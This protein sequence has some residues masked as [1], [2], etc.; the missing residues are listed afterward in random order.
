MAKA[1]NQ[2]QAD[3]V[4]IIRATTLVFSAAL[5]LVACSEPPAAVPA[6]PDQIAKIERVLER[7][8]E[9]MEIYEKAK[10]DD[11]VTEQEIIEILQQA[12]S[13]KDMREVKGDS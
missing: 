11:V 8:P 7:F 10:S 3:M 9:V 6:T 2:Q 13:I 1:R 5:V 4:G 12:Q